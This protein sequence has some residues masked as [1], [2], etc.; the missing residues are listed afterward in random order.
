MWNQNNY[1]RM[2]S[3]TKWISNRIQSTRAIVLELLASGSVNIDE[4]FPTPGDYLT[5]FTE[6]EADNCLILQ[7]ETYINL[8]KFLEPLV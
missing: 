4:Y 1:D 7:R 6:P 2:V 3:T 5:I 8:L